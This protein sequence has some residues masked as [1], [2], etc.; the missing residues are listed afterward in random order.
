MPV[1]RH[2]PGLRFRGWL[3]TV[4][5]NKWRDRI[6]QRA[7]QPAAVVEV[8]L[9]TLA[10]ADNVEEATEKEHRVYLIGRA[11]EL[12]QNE[13]PTDEWRACQE[14]PV[15]ARPACDVARELGMSVNQVYLIKSRILRRVRAELEEFLD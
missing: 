10:I 9:E 6:R 3:W 12:M 5:V 1:F 4:L 14:Y 11:V 7:A 8:D 13:L 15:K 2:D